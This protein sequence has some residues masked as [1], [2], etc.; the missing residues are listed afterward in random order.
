VATKKIELMSKKFI[1]SDDSVL[2]D[3]GFRVLTAG[4]RLD[5]FIKNPVGLF[6]HKRAD[7]WDIDKDSI[8]PICQWPDVMVEGNQLVGTPV[9]DTNDEF[10]V[11]IESK[12]DGGF[13]RMASIGIIPITT[14]SDPQYLLPGQKYETVVECLLVEISV[15]DIAS[16]PN[17]VALYDSERKLINLAAGA[18]N[19][20]IPLISIEQTTNPTSMKKIA[21]Q[22]GMKEDSTEEEIVE[23][24]K[25][26]QQAQTTLGSEMETIRLNSITKAVETAISEKRFTADKKDHFI[27]LGKTAGIDTLTTTIELMTPA[28]KITDVIDHKGSQSDGTITLKSLFEKGAKEVETF[29]AENPA[30][31]AKLYKEAYGIELKSET[32]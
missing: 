31:Y 16:N 23:A 30:E 4:I 13:I 26:A 22:L 25:K 28:K 29:K 27:N 2:N 10:A 11:Q 14:S 19:N 3:R 9:F 7:R 32:V 17:A 12:V 1:V 6:M 20:L 15:V 18:D 5:Q 24:V 21:I 8:L